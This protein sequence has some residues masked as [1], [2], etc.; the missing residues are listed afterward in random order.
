MKNFTKLSALTVFLAMSAHASHVIDLGSQGKTGRFCPGDTLSIDTNG[1]YIERMLISAEGIRNDGFIKVYADGE[2]VHNIGIP[3]Y[4]PDYTFRVRR[5]VKNISMKFERTCALIRDGKIFSPSPAPSNYRR[6]ERERVNNDNWGAEF[7]EI[8]RSLS[9]DLQFEAD[10]NSNLWPRVLLPMKKISLLQN[11]SE[12]V[13]DERSLITAHRS[14]KIAKIVID[15]E[16]LIERLLSNDHFDYLVSDLLRI[17]EDILERYDVKEKKV[18]EK[19]IELEE[20][21]GL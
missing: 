6:Y 18:N 20:E 8:S 15:N 3:G 2:L 19:I 14:L 7:L 5:N 11:A 1:Q 9:N 4:D 21:L 12:L 17:K 10:F 16:D 13:R